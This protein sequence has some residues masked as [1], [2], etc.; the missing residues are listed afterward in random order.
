MTIPSMRPY[1]TI[2]TSVM[3]LSPHFVRVTVS[4]ESLQ[5]F[6]I[7]GPDQRI[8]L[9][10]PR[11]DGSFPDIGLFTGPLPTV[12]EWFGRWR[13]LPAAERNPI[14]S[15]TVRAARP[16]A[17]EIDIDFVVHGDEGPASAWAM[18][19]QLGDELVIIGPDSRTQEHIGGME[20]HPGSATRVLLAGDETA[21]PA[22]AAILESLADHVTGHAYLEVPTVDDILTVQS[23]SAVEQHW[24]AREDAPLGDLLTK[25][26]KDWGAKQHR[27]K[28][29]LTEPVL[30]P[31]D[32][33]AVL[34]EVPEDTDRTEYIW[35]AGERSAIVGLRRHL[36]FDLG[37]DRRNIAFMGYWR[38]GHAES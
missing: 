29:R 35:L 27:P 22:I 28:H 33:E 21:V 15:Y 16:A 14:R 11:P 32:D 38:A 12:R 5:H 3:N 26:V 31:V 8:K 17:R 1:R 18:H 37:I 19:V 7:T 2:V 36:V 23:Q 9:F 20:W 34:W 24:M 30:D 13:A 6:T 25:A 10:F 4:D